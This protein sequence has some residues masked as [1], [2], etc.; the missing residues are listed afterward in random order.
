[1]KVVLTGGGTGGHI[2][3]LFAV[4]EQIQKICREEGVIAPHIYFYS[5]RNYYPDLLIKYG[6]DYRRVFAGKMRT[7]F[8]FQNFLDLFITIF[9]MI[10]SLYKLMSSYPDVIFSK[11]GYASF[12]VLFAARILGIP[13]FIHESDTIPGRISTWSARFAYRSAVSFARAATENNFHNAAHTGQPIMADLIPPPDFDRKYTYGRPV[14]LVTGG[15]QGSQTINNLIFVS[16]PQLL[17]T[18]NIIHVVGE[19]NIGFAKAQS[20]QILQDNLNAA[21]YALYGHAD[22][23]DIYPHVDI[24]VARGGATT[25]FELAQWQIPTV[26]IPLAISRANHQAENAFEAVK[27][28]WAKSLEESNLSAHMLIEALHSITSDVD[29]YNRYS[30]NAKDFGSANAANIIAREILDLLKS[31]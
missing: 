27:A 29:I 25:M 13:V 18:Y 11:G 1:M 10:A 19:E 26:F 5:D 23:A 21:N 8:S 7:Y 15:S 14:L 28:G 6:I 17:E 31:H 22:F 30:D 2:Y 4:A 9:G 16:L 12:P 20:K 3:P 24:A